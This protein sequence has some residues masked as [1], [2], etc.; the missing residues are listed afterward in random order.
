MTGR[1]SV[2]D[3]HASQSN[4]PEDAS[5]VTVSEGEEIVEEPSEG[6]GFGGSEAAQLEPTE[7][8]EG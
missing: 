5:E 4:A 8:V 1:D 7:A 6:E 3:G 2:N